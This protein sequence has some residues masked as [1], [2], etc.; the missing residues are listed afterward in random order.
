MPNKEIHNELENISVPVARKIKPEREWN[1]PDNY[2]S[3]NENF[4]MKHVS[5]SD[6]LP[7]K[8]PDVPDGYFEQNEKKMVHRIQQGT[9]PIKSWIRVAAAAAIVIAAIFIWQSPNRYKTEDAELAIFYLDENMDEFEA[10]D[11]VDY[12][13]VEEDIIASLPTIEVLSR[14]SLEAENFINDSGDF[15]DETSDDLF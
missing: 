4:L 13:L 2:F 9:L 7:A 6:G 11:F 1:V 15:F 5:L 12:Q 8:L 3:A 10:E 14:D